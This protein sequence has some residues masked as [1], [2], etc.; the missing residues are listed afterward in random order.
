MDVG[1]IQLQIDEVE[2]RG[3]ALVDFGAVVIFIFIL[4]EG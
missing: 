1:Y 2:V 3:K 4:V